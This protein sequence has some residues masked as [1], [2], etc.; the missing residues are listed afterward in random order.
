MGFGGRKLSISSLLQPRRPR[1]QTTATGIFRFLDLPQDLLELVIITTRPADV[2]ALERTCKAVR[3]ITSERRIWLDIAEVVA[4]QTGMFLQRFLFDNMSL[5]DIQRFA[6]SPDLFT[7]RLKSLGQAKKPTRSTFRLQ[8]RTQRVLPEFCPAKDPVWD[9]SYATHLTLVSGGRYILAAHEN[10]TE[11]HLRLL[12]LSDASD[13]TLEIF[14]I[15]TQSLPGACRLHDHWNPRRH[16]DVLRLAM[17]E[18]TPQSSRIAIFDVNTATERPDLTLVR[19]TSDLLPKS[20]SHS[21]LY[22]CDEARI[23]FCGECAIAI[24]EFTTDQLLTL[25]APAPRSF[26]DR[27]L[28]QVID[29]RVLYFSRDMILLYLL[30]EDAS[31]HLGALTF[32]FELLLSTEG[33]DNIYFQQPVVPH[34]PFTFHIHSW[35]SDTLR[36]YELPSCAAVLT[37]HPPRP[38]RRPRILQR[39]G[40]ESPRNPWAVQGPA[41]LAACGGT[42]FVP[43]L[44][45]WLHS[46]LLWLEPGVGVGDGGEVRAGHAE[47][48]HRDDFA[49]AQG[50]AFDPATGR[51]CVAN[52]AGSLLV[53]DYV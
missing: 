47:L 21:A 1:A 48:V 23:V 3:A 22:H 40:C 28:A 50:I 8:P 14:E 36:T 11:T 13:G 2:L 33:T 10:A 30:P 15:A 45:P 18:R 38:V 52:H 35:P 53:A 5:S 46:A 41:P 20:Y 9:R 51:L 37:A 49:R 44:S 29:K 12:R 32:S 16:P 34:K 4:Q 6:L 27:Y 24:W 39:E 31:G 17:L 43:R 26:H 7:R 42:H 25:D 19:R